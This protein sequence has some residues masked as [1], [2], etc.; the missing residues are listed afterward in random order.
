[1]CGFEREISVEP[2]N[3]IRTVVPQTIT[4]R[5]CVS[6]PVKLFMRVTKPMVKVT[7]EVRDGDIILA[8]KKEA[9]AKPS[10]MIAVSVPYEKACSARGPI[11][12]SVKEEVK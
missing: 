6:E 12:V 9:V 11:T 1:M 5:E 2:G 3:A 4:V 8:S 10:E 7:V